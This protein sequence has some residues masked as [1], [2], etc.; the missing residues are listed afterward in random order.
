MAGELDRRQLLQLSLAAVALPAC[1]IMSPEEVPGEGLS[2]IF[3]V[4]GTTAL[5]WAHV[6]GATSVA[7]VVGDEADG[8]AGLRRTESVAVDPAHGGTV[9]VELSGLLPG[10]GYRLMVERDDG[11]RLAPCRFVTAPEAEAD[12]PVFL[13]F[14]GDYD[15]REDAGAPILDR[16]AAAAP[17]FFVSMGDW[18]Y[19]DDAGGAIPLADYRAAHLSSRRTDGARRL[20]SAAS[21]RAIYDDHEVRNDW[22]AALWATE[23]D[24]IRAALTAW[25]EWFAVRGAA[26]GARYRAWRWGRHLD[27]ILLDTRLYRSANAA[28]DG[29]DKTM[30]GAEQ[31]AWL[32]DRLRSSTATFKLVFTSVP[33]GFGMG[34][35]HWSSFAFER[36]AM[37]AALR[38]AGVTGL[39][40]LAGDQH[41][42]AAHRHPSGAREFQV[43]PL[44]RGLPVPPP[45][46]PGVLMR[47]AVFNYGEIRIA[48]GPAPRL[49]FTCRDAEGAA[50]HA[51]S[52]AAGELRA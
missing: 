2:A 26:P 52:F 28:S 9:E 1:G 22:D 45:P 49:H 34:D 6:P 16:I 47:M 31:L 10:R 44:A 25:D 13:A 7:L 24:G 11:S 35:D 3:E 50:L 29:P 42:F 17:D 12:A 48:P 23:G 37:L 21:F 14:S 43:G 8:D 27:C 39:L 5:V 32:L 46:E 51:E 20:F 38:E 15:E 36:E 19:A 41:W 30:L 4:E 40:F 18:P 33:L